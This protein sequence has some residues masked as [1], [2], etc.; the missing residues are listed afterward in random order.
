MEFASHYLFEIT[1]TGELVVSKIPVCNGVSLHEHVHFF[2]TEIQCH[3][4][5]LT[6]LKKRKSPARLFQKPKN[7]KA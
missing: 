1:D 2:G 5:K 7:Q 6:L 4:R 3:K